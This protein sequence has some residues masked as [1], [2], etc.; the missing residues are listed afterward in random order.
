MFQ[1]RTEAMLDQTGQ[2]PWPVTIPT[3]TKTKTPNSETKT[4]RRSR[5]RSK[6]MS[7]WHWRYCTW[8]I[9]T[10]RQTH[11]NHQDNMCSLHFKTRDVLLS[12]LGSKERSRPKLDGC[13]TKTLKIKSRESRCLETKTWVLKPTSLDAWIHHRTLKC[14]RLYLTVA[15]ANLNRF[16][17]FLSRSNPEWMSPV[18]AV[19]PTS[20]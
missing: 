12:R 19:L 14:S 11:N 4:K 8:N 13:R 15:L 18:T 2:G 5:H 3:L 10:W 7:T 20:P 9:T 6:L 16:L 1:D 17:E